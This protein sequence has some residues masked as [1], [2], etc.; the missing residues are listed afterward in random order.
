M[1][2]FSAVGIYT[3]PNSCDMKP[4]CKP[5]CPNTE[6]L[7]AEGQSICKSCQELLCLCLKS[8]S[9]VLTLNVIRM[10]FCPEQENWF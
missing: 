7:F 3:L 10:D 9:N 4:F 5:P 8:K 6:G 2:A 1:A